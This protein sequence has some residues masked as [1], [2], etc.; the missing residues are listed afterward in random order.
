M[1]LLSETDAPNL[2]F[3]YSSSQRPIRANYQAQKLKQIVVVA[4]EPD[5]TFGMFSAQETEWQAILNGKVED[6][7]VL[8]AGRD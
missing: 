4:S 1:L 2:A 7:E 6:A 8:P 3:T 5:R